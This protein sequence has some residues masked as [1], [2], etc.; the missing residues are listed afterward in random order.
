M[1]GARKRVNADRDARAV[2]CTD[3][4]RGANMAS[5]D[6]IEVVRNDDDQR[7][8]LRKGGERVGLIDFRPR[9]DA[10]ALTHTEVS[11]DHSGQGLAAVLVRGALEQIDAAGLALLPH[12]PY[13]RGYL[14]RHPEWV[15]LVPPDQRERFDLA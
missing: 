15:R 9:G 8:E 4:A 6:D 11:P 5:M 1:S 10:L 3:P 12:C 13:V 7:F 2:T 14:S